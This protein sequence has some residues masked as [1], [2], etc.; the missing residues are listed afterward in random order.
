MSFILL[1]KGGS[2]MNSVNLL[3]AEMSATSFPQAHEPI[4]CP[5]TEMGTI[6]AVEFT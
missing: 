6:L 4:S 5:V 1:S 3:V 2:S